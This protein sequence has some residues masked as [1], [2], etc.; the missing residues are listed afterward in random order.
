MN[1]NIITREVRSYLKGF[2]IAA[3]TVSVFIGG[4]M[5]MYGGMKDNM[6]ALLDTGFYDSIPEALTEALYFHTNQWSSVLGFYVTYFLYFILMV[7]A[8]YSFSLGNRLLASEEQDKTAEF[9]LSRPVTR[10]ETVLSKIVVLLFYVFSINL[11]G[12]LVG[13]ISCGLTSDWNYNIGALA[14]LHTYGFLYCFFFAVLGMTIAAVMKRASVITGIGMGIVM[15]LY[16]L[17]VIV[18]I[19]Q[20]VKFILFLT[21]L[22]YVDLKVIEPDYGF[23]VWRIAV[24]AVVT[25]LLIGGTLYFYRKKD[26]LV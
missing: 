8:V 20:Q 13:F 16:F 12:F 5:G 19:I 4:T 9:L 7:A 15:A 18:R 25:A 17:N 23:E 2:I 10:D 22:H 26:I 14:V 3:L 6:A 21:P 24:F 1:M 11:I